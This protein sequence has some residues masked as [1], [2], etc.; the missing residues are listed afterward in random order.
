[1]AFDFVLVGHVN[2]EAQNPDLELTDFSTD[3]LINIFHLWGVDPGQVNIFTASDGHGNGNHEVRRYSAAEYYTRAGFKKTNEKILNMRNSNKEYMQAERAISTH[4]KADWLDLVT[5]F[6][7][8]LLIF[9]FYCHS[10][11]IV[12][13]L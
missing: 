2:Q 9:M 8:F 10:M 11:M 6:V 1:M 12:S 4:K 5:M 7:L 13:F 3:K